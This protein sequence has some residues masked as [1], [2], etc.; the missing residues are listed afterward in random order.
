[1]REEMRRRPVVWFF[2]LALAI[3]VAVVAL[4][5][6]TGAFDGLFTAQEAAG[7]AG[8]TDFVA[9]GQLVAGEP[10]LLPDAVLVVLQPF[11][12]DIAAFLVAGLAFGL[13]GL[14]RIVRGYRFWSGDVGWRRGLRVW[15]LMAL[16]FIAMSLATAGLDALFMPE[17]TWGWDPNLLS[18]GFPLVLLWSVFLDVGGVSE[19]TGWRGFA[20][21][22]LQS[23]MTPLAATLVVGVM[24]G[25]WHLPARPDIL[26]GAYGQGG[27]VVLLVVLVVRFVFLS[28][29]VTYFYN[30]VGGSTL[31]AIAMH[32]LHNDSVGLMGRIAGGGFAPYMISE[33]ALLAPI[34]AVAVV[35]LFVS[36]RKLGLGVRSAMW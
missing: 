34:V 22:V 20:L 31:I 8:R 23:R 3:E 18:L 19:E 33:L 12:P 16:T 36:G 26:A 9:L 15:G 13:V 17:G 6:V 32:G 35:V 30:R 21:P 11:S 5:L 14:K 2:A 27:G 1:M 4:A 29:V 28:V 7:L 10:S 24:W 25:V